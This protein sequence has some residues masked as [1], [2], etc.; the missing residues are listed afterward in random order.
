MSYGKR[1]FLSEDDT[2]CEQGDGRKLLVAQA[3]ATGLLWPMENMYP[4]LVSW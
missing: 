3:R 4:G 1:I 2:D